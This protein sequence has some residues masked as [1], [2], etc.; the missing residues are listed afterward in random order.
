MSLENIEL[1]HYKTKQKVSV[2]A[3][4]TGENQFMASCINPDHEDK[5]PSMSISTDKGLYHCFACQ[6]AGVTW[7]KH[8]ENKGS[9][10]SGEQ[11]LKEKKEAERKNEIILSLNTDLVNWS[12]YDETI[13][14]EAKSRIAFD[15]CFLPEKE[16]VTSISSVVEA[17]IFRRVELLDRMKKVEG[18]LKQS[19]FTPEEE[20]ILSKQK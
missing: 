7:A 9:K 8:L 18:L 2:L 19:E 12:G 20:K 6:I 14:E 3:R 1:Y 13:K 5:H 4:K 11:Y 17:G 15:L 16:K 10:K